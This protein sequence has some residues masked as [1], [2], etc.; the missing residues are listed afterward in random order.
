MESDAD[1]A[2]NPSQALAQFNSNKSSSQHASKT[3][4]GNKNAR[5][6]RE[7]RRATPNG[8]GVGNRR[9]MNISEKFAKGKPKALQ[10]S[11]DTQKEKTD[12]PMERRRA[13]RDKSSEGAVDRKRSNSSSN[14]TGSTMMRRSSQSKGRNEMLN[15]AK[16]YGNQVSKKNLGGDHQMPVVK[17]V[18]IDDSNH[19]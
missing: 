14:R 4:S 19:L 2:M 3:S 5:R 12:P 10:T 1:L 15:R 7:S 11:T 16:A 18:D 8:S 17:V 13:S 6:S 9:N